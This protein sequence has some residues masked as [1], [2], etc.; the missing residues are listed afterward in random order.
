LKDGGEYLSESTLHSRFVLVDSFIQNA[1]II[2]SSTL[3]SKISGASLLINAVH[4]AS[5]HLENVQIQESSTSMA[6]IQT[7]YR[8]ILHAEGLVLKNNNARVSILVAEDSQAFITHS[9]FQQDSALGVPISILALSSS[10]VTVQQ[11]CLP[12]LQSPSTTSVTTAPQTAVTE[13]T[14]VI[15]VDD[16]SSISHDEKTILVPTATTNSAGSETTTTSATSSMAMLMGESPPSFS[17]KGPIWV[18][19]G[20]GDCLDQGHCSG[21]C[22][23]MASSDHCPLS[24]GDNQWTSSVLQSSSAS[25]IKKPMAAT[26]HSILIANMVVGASILILGQYR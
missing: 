7:Q 5:L 13:T 4:G 3:I 6:L 17:C 8:S 20:P 24:E 21:R 19:D 23:S 12:T 25:T 26:M 9:Q 22:Q 11:S 18:L 15:V 14:P 2:L 1:R 10:Q 16:S